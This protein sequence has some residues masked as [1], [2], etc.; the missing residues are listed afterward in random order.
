M[1]R[2]ATLIF[3][4]AASIYV[5]FAQDNQVTLEECYTDAEQNYPLI[6]QLDLIEKAE[7]YNISNAMRRRL[8]SFVMNGQETYQSDITQVPIQMPELQIEPPSKHQ[9]KVYGEVSMKIFDGGTIRHEQQIAKDNASVNEQQVKVDLYELK[10]RVNEIYFGILIHDARL[11]QNQLL[12]DEIER[13]IRQVRAAIEQGTALKSSVD[14]LQAEQLKAQQQQIEFR[15]NRKAYIE[16]LARMTGKPL[17]EATVFVTPQTIQHSFE[18]KR[19]ELLLFA[20]EKASLNVHDRMIS[21]RLLPKLSLFFQGGYGRPALNMLENSAEA[22]YVTGFRLN[23]TISNFY[24]AKNDRALLDIKRRTINLQE[25][26]FRFNTEIALKQQRNE[27]EKLQQTL[28]TDDRIIEIREKIRNT[29]ASQL[30]NGVIHVND[31]VQQVTAE[32]EARQN[33]ALHEVMLLFAQYKMKTTS[34]I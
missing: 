30:A 27:I 4:F 22:Y 16:M 1:K 32:D 15:A 19:P 18:V 12:Q 17:N 6:R 10:E 11:R 2:A 21:A 13:G 28:Q 26:T 5:A 33:K 14:A 20:R 34:G 23:W 31:Y 3:F 7:A 8:P 25:E 9:Y 24:T 29:A